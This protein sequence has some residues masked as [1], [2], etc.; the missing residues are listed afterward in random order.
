MTG[1]GITTSAVLRATT[2][3]LSAVP[4]W[5]HRTDL[6]VT[7]SPNPI[8]GDLGVLRDDGEEVQCHVCAEWF[9]HLPAHT[10]QPHR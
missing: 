8:H 2:H 9:M 3:A 7:T 10:Y 4:G 6:I 1:I 5:G